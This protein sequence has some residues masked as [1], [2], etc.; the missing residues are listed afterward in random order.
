MKRT[1]LAVA[2]ILLL[3][4]VALAQCRG[5]V[6]RP[7][8]VVRKPAVVVVKK[9][10]AT[11]VFLRF[12]AV[13]PLVSLPTYSASALPVPA[14]PPPVP[15]AAQPQPDLRPVLEAIGKMGDRL[16]GIEKRLDS[17]EKRRRIDAPPMPPAD[18]ASPKAELPPGALSA[19]AK[20]AGCHAR[21]SEAKGGDFVLTEAGGTAFALLDAGDWQAVARRLQDP[22]KPMP[23]RDSGVVL[24]PDERAALTRYATEAAA[25]YRASRRLRNARTY[26]VRR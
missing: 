17:L 22:R 19:A 23:P 25:S 20:C 5:P 15:A 7:V 6:C 24:T 8:V 9:V 14:P 21:G 4:G 12:D 3:G 16:G 11:P 13:I 18:P 1:L 26:E 10:V 2:A